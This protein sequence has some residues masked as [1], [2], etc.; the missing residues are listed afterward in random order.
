VAGHNTTTSPQTN[1]ASGVLTWHR[2]ERVPVWATMLEQLPSSPVHSRPLQARNHVSSVLLHFTLA[3]V[4]SCCIHTLSPAFNCGQPRAETNKKHS[5]GWHASK[6]PVYVFSTYC[7]PLVAIYW[8]FFSTRSHS[9]KGSN[10]LQIGRIFRHLPTPLD[11]LN[12]G[13]SSSYQSGSYLVR[14]N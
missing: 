1:R 2:V 13:V 5:C 11:A 4:R 10:W 6:T 7:V 8:P 9:P 14:E 12:D 3:V